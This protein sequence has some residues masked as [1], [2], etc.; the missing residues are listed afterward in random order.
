MKARFLNNAT[1]LIKTK[2]DNTLIFD[3]WLV[4]D[5]YHG[6]WLPYFTSF[7]KEEIENIKYIFISHIHQDHWDVETLKLIPK[8]AKIFLPD[9]PV[10]RVVEN[11]IRDIGFDVFEYISYEDQ[12]VID[13]LIFKV[14]PNLNSFG[15]D[16]KLYSDDSNDIFNAIDCGLCIINEED[17][18]ISYLFADNTPYNIERLKNFHETILKQYQ[19]N[20]TCFVAFPF[21]SF[22]SDY[23]LCY[24][25][26]SIEERKE[27]SLNFNLKRLNALEKAFNYLDPNFGIPHSSDYVLNSPYSKIFSEINEKKFSSRTFFC[28]EHNNIFKN[29]LLSMDPTKYLDITNNKVVTDSINNFSISPQF[30]EINI[31]EFDNDLDLFE[32]IKESIKKYRLR[33]IKKNLTRF[34]NSFYF[35]N[36]LTRK[37]SFSID[38][39]ND[40]VTE[41]KYLSIKEI[42]NLNNDTYIVGYETTSTIHKAILLNKIHISNAH[43]GCYL[44]CFRNTRDFNVE[45]DYSLNFFSAV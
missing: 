17:Q 5:Q 42:S 15:Q 23:P 6:T 34:K 21:N 29:R 2:N 43:A 20:K 37:K 24:E 18:N 22:A 1:S 13:D 39:Y 40:K 28:N 4:G 26:L 35:L 7:N 45:L 31:P 14:I 30:N 27:I 11:Y 41:E 12:F 10:N 3:P 25:S 44:N 32:L 19:V 16:L 38:L 33:C 8:D 9:I 36:D